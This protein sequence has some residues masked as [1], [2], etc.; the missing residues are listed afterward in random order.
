MIHQPPIINYKK[1]LTASTLTIIALLTIYS[2][3]F[4][5]RGVSGHLNAAMDERLSVITSLED[6]RLKDQAMKIEACTKEHSDSHDLGLPLTWDLESASK[7]YAGDVLQYCIAK[8]K[9]TSSN[10]EEHSTISRLEILIK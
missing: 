8:F 5:T 2:L 6:Q 7:E 1:L 10:L 9:W 4:F 3:L